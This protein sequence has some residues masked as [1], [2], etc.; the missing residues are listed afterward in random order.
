METQRKVTPEAGII[1]SEREQYETLVLG[2]RET[3]RGSPSTIWRH[4]KLSNLLQRIEGGE[5]HECLWHEAYRIEKILHPIATMKVSA[6]IVMLALQATIADTRRTL[7]PAEELKAMEADIRATVSRM[8]P[9]ARAMMGL[10][11]RLCCLQGTGIGIDFGREIVDEL[12]SPLVVDKALRESGDDPDVKIMRKAY[13][14]ACQID[15][16]ERCE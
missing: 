13:D 10:L 6:K 3:L 5:N 11:E 8:E 1:A 4:E 15:E 7:D 14:L 9:K 16:A 12:D 2:F